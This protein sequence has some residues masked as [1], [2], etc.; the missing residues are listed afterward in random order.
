ML[1]VDFAGE[2][3]HPSGGAPFVIGRDG[4]LAISDNPY[5]HRR[6]LEITREGDLWW[7]ANVGSQTSATV[8]DPGSAVHAWLAPGGRLP[9]GVGTTTIRFTA[10]PSDY[11][12]LLTLSGPSEEPSGDDPIGDGTETVGHLRLT[13]DQ[14]LML[15]VLAE[16]A[17]RHGMAGMA[18]IPSA[19]AAARRIGWT[20][21][22]FEKKID[23]VCDRLA[24]MGVRGVKGELG[25]QAVSRRVRLVEFALSTR[26]VTVDDL[27]FLDDVGR[28]G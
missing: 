25:N 16:S 6:F 11:E 21:K 2:I 22:R 1:T 26:L 19:S 5:L 23:N 27:A 17:L 7:I 14:R 8:N 3:H 24:G 15:V 12:L 9:V 18:D 28:G 4:D 20:Q 10:G 13:D